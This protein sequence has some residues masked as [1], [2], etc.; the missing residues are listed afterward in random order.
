MSPRAPEMG[1]K[2]A[3]FRVLLHTRVIGRL[4]SLKKT[5]ASSRQFVDPPAMNERKFQRASMFSSSDSFIIVARQEKPLVK[6]G[7]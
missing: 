6:N 2:V 3:F 4:F 5:I 7:F 1:E